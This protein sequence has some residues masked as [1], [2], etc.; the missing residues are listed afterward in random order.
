MQYDTQTNH[1]ISTALHLT[2][3]LDRIESMRDTVR[4]AR[5]ISGAEFAAVGVLDSRGSLIDPIHSQDGDTFPPR[6]LYHELAPLTNAISLDGPLVI[7]GESTVAQTLQ[8]YRE[9]QDNDPNAP[10]PLADTREPEHIRHPLP[11]PV[12]NFLGIAIPVHGQIWARLFLINKPGGFDTNDVENM[13]LLSQAAAIAARNSRVYN[14]A[15]NRARW[16]TASQNIVASL[17]EGSDEEEALQ[18]IT[19]EM[20][21]AAQADIAMMILPSIGGAWMCEFAA[22]EDSARFIGLNFPPRGR[23]RTVAR[24]QAAVVVD[25]MQRLARVRVAQLRE[26]GPAL[27]APLSSQGEG[28]GVI[29]LLRHPGD[30]EFD[31]HDLSMAE[32]VAQQATIALQ[33]AEARHNKEL[34][35]ELD[36][37]ARISRDLHDLAIQQLFASGMHVTAVKEDLEAKGA[38]AEILASLDDAIWAIDESVTQIRQIVRSLRDESSPLALVE[39]LQ[40]EMTVALQTL[41]FAP[42]LVLRWN[43]EPVS[44]SDDA[45]FIDDAVGSD[46]SDDVVAVVRE[47]LSNASRHAHASSVSV[48]VAVSDSEITV[49]VIDDGDGVSRSLSRRSG[50]SNLA[51]R[52]RRHHGSFSLHSRYP[53]EGVDGSPAATP[54]SGTVRRG[55]IMTWSAP[56]R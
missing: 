13:Q 24:E 32:N 3:Q 26:F 14:E 16:L 52:A 27:Y 45:T 55:A 48:V 12:E 28:I 8:S 2:Q 17:L 50:L 30:I 22:G 10:E 37:R 46:I 11:C 29:L 7:N 54:S 6:C 42:S 44:D 53:E 38:S 1:I 18:T 4:S 9:T 49:E 34:A 41:G 15:K 20:R 36:E 5:E 21:T 33:L 43:G 40:H 51:A 56:L 19:E 25:S 47:G 23:A 39:R 31:L 35:V